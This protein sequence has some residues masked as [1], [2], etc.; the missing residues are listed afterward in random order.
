[1]SV[2]AT[3]RVWSD[4]SVGGSELLILLALADYANPAGFCYPSTPSIAA[5]VRLSI[6]QTGRILDRL[7]Q[8][9]ALAVK[10]QSQ[11][12]RG[13]NNKYI[14]LVGLSD[15]EIA[16]ALQR[17]FAWKKPQ[18]AQFINQRNAYL[19]QLGD[20]IKSF[21]VGQ[22]KD[23]IL[24]PLEDSMDD[25]FAN[26][27]DIFGDKDD[28]AVS[29]DPLTHEPLY[30]GGETPPAKQA[31]MRIPRGQPKQVQADDF[32]D[33]QMNKQLMKAYEST[34][35][36]LGFIANRAK[37]AETLKELHSLGVTPDEVSGAILW[38]VESWDKNRTWAFPLSRVPSTIRSW[39]NQRK[40]AV[41]SQPE[42]YA[43]GV[44]AARQAMRKKRG[45][46]N[47]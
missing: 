8:V 16:H 10:P 9:F 17:H 21:G 47:G 25:I 20:E 24:S 28:I 32:P 1:M 42:W 14:I 29:P 46:D 36:G 39:R 4:A 45:D 15:A 13:N 38:A 3:N 11:R 23:D 44:D 41:P 33:R 26:K 6:R 43:N 37:A 31:K 19:A 2:P 5:M 40:T 35:E 30:I 22:N 7:E 27:G 34:V 12:G 18:V